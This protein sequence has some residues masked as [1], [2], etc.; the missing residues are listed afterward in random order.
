MA[1]KWMQNEDVRPWPRNILQIFIKRVFASKVAGPRNS[2]LRSWSKKYRVVIKWKG[3]S[4]ETDYSILLIV[5]A[6]SDVST[7]AE[8]ICTNYKQYLHSSEPAVIGRKNMVCLC[9]Y[10]EQINK[11]KSYNLYISNCI[12]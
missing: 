9:T 4:A 6:E 12:L 1:L 10:Y 8:T 5:G 3:K 2:N 11:K 7:A